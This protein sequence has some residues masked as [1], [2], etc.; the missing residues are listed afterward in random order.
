MCE[1]MSFD[2]LDS[3]DKIKKHVISIYVPLDK[4]GAFDIEKCERE[5]GIK[6]TSDELKYLSSIGE[7][8]KVIDG[9]INIIRLSFTA[10]FSVM[11]IFVED[12]ISSSLGRYDLFASK[13]IINDED[14]LPLLMNDENGGKVTAHECAMFLTDYIVDHTID[15]IKVVICKE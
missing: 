4:M 6:L 14:V 9:K 11:D 15:D 5:S 3:T 13:F 1:S 7:L 10:N 12:F 2:M 8:I